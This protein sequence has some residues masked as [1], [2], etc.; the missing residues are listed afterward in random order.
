MLLDQAA[1][2]V[3]WLGAF[4]DPVFG[5]IELDGAV[6]TGFL[7]IVRADNLDEFPVARAVAISHDHSVI[8]AILGAFSP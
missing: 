7:W 1:D 2:R 3:G 6:V 8:R 4:T 5:A